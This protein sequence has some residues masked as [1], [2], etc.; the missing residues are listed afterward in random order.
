[1]SPFTRWGNAAISKNLM[2]LFES[3]LT[4]A[5]ADSPKGALWRF[6]YRIS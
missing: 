3:V 5:T 4:D 1:M 6:S 2:V